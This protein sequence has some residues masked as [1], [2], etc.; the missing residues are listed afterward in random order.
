[1]MVDGAV[2]SQ[3]VGS[4]IILRSPSQNTEKRCIKFNFSLSNNQAEYETL[5]I[6][7]LWAQEV[8]I[9]SLEVSCDSQ[10]VI[11]QTNCDYTANS[12]NLRGYTEMERKLKRSLKISYCKR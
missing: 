7:L 10:V 5:I 11:G 2:N 6:E 4:G 3:G 12:D 1:M 8:G 9:Q